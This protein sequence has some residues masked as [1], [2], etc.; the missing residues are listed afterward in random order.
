MTNVPN[1]LGGGVTEIDGFNL[2]EFLEGDSDDA[3]A[4]RNAVEIY[5]F[6][7]EEKEKSCPSNEKI[8]DWTG[9]LRR[10]VEVLRLRTKMLQGIPKAEYDA[11]VKET[12]TKLEEHFAKADETLE[13]AARAA[14]LV[15]SMG[16]PNKVMMDTVLKRMNDFGKPAMAMSYDILN[17][18]EDRLNK[19]RPI[20]ALMTQM[21]DFL[22]AEL[23]KAA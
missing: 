9:L 3:A 21:I 19:N 11:I 12:Q 16:L 8:E 4:V 1:F 5:Q 22:E 6:L 20:A 23:A 17:R 2:F 13:D 7:K 15:K 10:G 14:D 18:F